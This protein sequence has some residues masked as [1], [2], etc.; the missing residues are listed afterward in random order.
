MLNKLKE[1]KAA[2]KAAVLEAFKEGKIIAVNKKYG[3][4]IKLTGLV[5]FVSPLK[6]LAALSTKKCYLLQE[7]V[8]KY[9]SLFVTDKVIGEMIW[10]GYPDP[11]QLTHYNEECTRHNR[12]KCIHC[13]DGLIYYPS[14]Q[15]LFEALVIEP[16]DY[17]SEFIISKILPNRIG[18]YKFDEFG[19]IISVEYE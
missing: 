7:C 13:L 17:G 19:T 14:K 5:E 9:N 10:G 8:I 15:S 4:K 12:I 6:G 11:Y 16:D 2:E 3:D 1:K 18:Y